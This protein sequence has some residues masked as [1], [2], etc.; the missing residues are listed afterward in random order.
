MLRWVQ[1]CAKSSIQAVRNR[2]ALSA[3]VYLP[4][5]FRVK[6]DLQQPVLGV[7]PFAASRTYQVAAPCGS[8]MIVVFGDRKGFSAAAGDE[9]H[10]Q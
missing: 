10:A 5:S 2:P 9:E 1:E 4:V 7:V 3:V 8:L 6:S